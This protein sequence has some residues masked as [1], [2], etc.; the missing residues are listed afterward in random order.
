MENPMN[1]DESSPEELAGAEA[2]RRAL[3]G[4]A[5]PLG[6]LAARRIVRSALTEAKRKW[7]RRW[8]AGVLTGA[9][10][11]ALALIMVALPGMPRQWTSRSG[12]L[13]VPGPFSS[14]QT[15]AQRLDVVAA[16]RLGA[17]RDSSLYGVRR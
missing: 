9:V 2:L 10:A 13:L 11:A 16:N 4:G 3:D 15:A 12:G 8:S 7:L 17:F 6:E 5:P 14:T 1:D